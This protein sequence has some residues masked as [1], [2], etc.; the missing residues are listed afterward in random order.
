MPGA[1]AAMAARLFVTRLPADI[2][3]DEVSYIFGKYGKVVSVELVHGVRGG[4]VAIQYRGMALAPV[5]L[6][7]LPTAGGRATGGGRGEQACAFV[8]YGTGEAA[9]IAIRVLNNVYSVR[10]SSK[11]P[12]GVR[13]ATSDDLPE[14][15]FEPPKPSA[16]VIAAANTPQFLTP[17]QTANTGF[18]DGPTTSTYSHVIA[19][20][21]CKLFIG[22]LHPDITQM[23]LMNVF[24]TWGKVVNVHIKTGKSKFG[25]ACAYLELARPEQ[26]EMARL[27]LHNQFDPRIGAG[28][29]P[30][31]VTFFQSGGGRR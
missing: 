21:K 4:D 16:E 27:A 9:E 2:K 13:L 7:L 30:I 18:S 24:A 6:H 29:A 11:D 28:G 22:N 1:L 10:S 26:A 20:A 23:A 12:I 3:E 5:E 17:K 15:P 14:T 25:S 19:K 8:T 31:Q